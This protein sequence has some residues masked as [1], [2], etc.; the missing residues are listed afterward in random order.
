MPGDQAFVRATDSG[1]AVGN[2]ALVRAVRATPGRQGCVTRAVEN[3]LTGTRLAVAGP[4]CVV[5]LDRAG[6]PVTAA[7]CTV[8]DV[9]AERRKRA[10]AALVVDL[11]HPATDLRLT[12][13]YEARPGT[14][15]LRKRLVLHAGDRLV[16]QVAVDALDLRGGHRARFG[17]FG[18]P[19]FLD[20][21]FFLGLE[22]PAG[23]NRAARGAQQV[24][25]V[26]FPG[27]AGRVE[28]KSAVL[29]VAS[30]AV[31]DR[32]RDRFL[33]YVD[34]HRAQRPT[35][36]QRQYS[37]P[38]DDRTLRIVGRTFRDRGLPVHG[39]YLHGDQ[40]VF[41]ERGLMDLQP[42]DKQ[43]AR[44]L[45]RGKL[46]GPLTLDALR[47]KAARLLGG[48][49]GFHLN[50]GGGRH[51]ADH[52]YSRERFDM[53]S[54][55]YYCMADR[56]VQE[57]MRANLVKLIERYDAQFFSFDWLWWTTAWECPHA[58]H[59]GHI[60]GARYGREAI[61]DAFI[62]L[63]RALRRAKPTI[64]LEDLEVEL[65]PWW[66]W[67]VDALW[68]Y[69]GEGTKL[70]HEL[71]DGSLR[72]WL[73][74]TTVYPMNGLW[75]AVNPPHGWGPIP[76]P[77]PCRDGEE[78]VARWRTRYQGLT[79][80]PGEKPLREF[81]DDLILHYLRGSPIDEIYYRIPDLTH[82]ERRV[83]AQ[84]MAWARDRERVQLAD[85]VYVLGDPKKRQVY[86]LVHMLDTNRGLLG[87]YNP[88]PWRDAT[89]TLR[90][91][92][93]ARLRKHGP[94]VTLDAV[95]PWRARIGDGLRWGDRVRATVPGGSLVV[96]ETRPA[97]RARR[98]PPATVRAAHA[99][100]A[101]GVRVANL[102]VRTTGKR[103]RRVRLAFDLGLEENERAQLVVL[104]ETDF[105][106]E[107]ILTTDRLRR[108]YRTLYEETLHKAT[109]GRGRR[110]N[111][112]R[113]AESRL[114][115]QHA[116]LADL[117]VG[118]PT[119]AATRDG[120]P[121]DL[122]AASNARHKLIRCARH[123]VRT[124]AVRAFSRFRSTAPLLPGR[125]AVEATLP[126]PATVLHAWLKRTCVLADAA[127]AEH[128]HDTGHAAAP[129][130]A[131]GARAQ[132]PTD[133]HHRP[134]ACVLLVG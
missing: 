63:A 105:D 130:A 55:D 112:Q 1:F 125:Y 128:A 87:L 36:R 23:T 132:L 76:R 60:R 93:A 44:D 8:R 46:E 106:E 98:G 10:G 115:A 82:D 53:I 85:A 54:P 25:L 96:F 65:S 100:P 48:G 104:A 29:G 88:C 123:P 113:R 64:V 37:G 102:R 110:E 72:D 40:N 77:D 35:A 83:Y 80:E 26:H 73:R 11:V 19:L 59:R 42:R 9:R 75:Y 99:L 31:N 67:W 92:E 121:V 52:A 32:V 103:T 131:S 56:R 97:R 13:R 27:R 20:D 51:S 108:R 94:P 120:R 126:H 79:P 43:F 34:R 47:R 49:L 57:K 50:T 91:D 114:A 18:Q 134:R 68:T 109:V 6:A 3:R 30:N 45:S 4:E 101:D 78:A 61:T 117:V 24:R 118:R 15:W 12:I 86:G 107:T 69:A 70:S 58:G 127:A 22:Y 89:V 21:E 5:R 116:I 95:Y 71:V 111:A 33:G 17:G 14:W 133:F 62:D 81:A 39:I 66:L 129:A 122:D 7:A 16:R 124:A 90:L 74:K 38:V 119:C 84:V 41:R 28:A 2:G